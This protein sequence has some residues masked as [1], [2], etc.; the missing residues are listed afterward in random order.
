MHR[1]K[2]SMEKIAGI[3]VFSDKGV[4]K[5]PRNHAAQTF[6]TLFTIPV[7][8]HNL[9]KLNNRKFRINKKYIIS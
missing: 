1:I 8:R 6:S 2:N 5:N 9:K 4:G 3:F 7:S